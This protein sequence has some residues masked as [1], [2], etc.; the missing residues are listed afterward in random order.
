M[1]AKPTILVWIAVAGALAGAAP[2]IAQQSTGTPAPASATAGGSYLPPFPPPFTG[3]V[4]RELLRQ[5]PF[6]TWRS[7]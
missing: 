7:P 6:D 5:R 2:A 3:H 4:G 1:K